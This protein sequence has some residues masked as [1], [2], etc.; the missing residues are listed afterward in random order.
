[1]GGSYGSPVQRGFSAAVADQAG[2]RP[3]LARTQVSVRLFNVDGDNH[4]SPQTLRATALSASSPPLAA[5]ATA[6]GVGASDPPSATPGTR[7][8]RFAGIANVREHLARGMLING[9]FQ[10][11]LVAMSAVRGFVVAIFLTRS[12][13]GLWGLIGLT[14]WTALGLKTQ[15]GATEKYVQ[16][17]DEDDEQAFQ[18][19]FTIELLFAGAA[20][21]LAIAVLL[22]V[23]A[24]TGDHRI[25]VPSLILL[26][27]LP[28][29]VVQF[30]LAVFYRKLDFRRQ[31]MLQ[32]VD[33]VIATAV[34]IGLAALGAGYWSF[35]IGTLAGAWAVALVVWR[36]SPYRLALRYERGT[37]GQ[38]LGFSWPLLVGAFATL[39]LFYGI[40]LEGSAVIGVAALGAFTLAGN[41]VQF[42]DQADDIITATLYPAVCAVKERLALL[43][44]VFVK[45]NRL[46]LMWAVPFGVGVALFASDLVR[47]VLG[48]RWSNAVPVLVI[49]GLVTAVHHVGYNW[50]AFVKARGTTWPLAVSGVVVNSV[51][52]GSSIFLMRRYGV[53]GLGLA[54]ALGEAVGFVIRGVWLARFFTGVRILSHLM[55]AFAPTILA[56]IPI[57]LLRQ[58]AGEEQTLLAAAAVFALYVGLTLAATALLERPLMREAVGYM[59]RRANSIPGAA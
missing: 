18:R 36:A 42:T 37:L 53:T 21:P 6:A 19:A 34:M 46:S 17:S 38:Y 28:A 22:A 4:V 40:Y 59:L 20:A 23:V 26:L 8:R 39:G 33:P 50:S 7:P 10:L 35:V 51:V 57:I 13:Y 52:V 9:G 2:E 16:L 55:R 41:I 27:L 24:I 1:M 31:R 15:F 48:P 43:S 44:E 32:A 49:M 30:P 54:F 25:L 29:T 56:C 11:G 14:I 5:P 58:V 3:E 12:D 47:L 45:S